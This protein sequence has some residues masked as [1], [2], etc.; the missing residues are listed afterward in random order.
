MSSTAGVLAAAL[1]CT[2]LPAAAASLELTTIEPIPGANDVYSFAGAD[3]D[4]VNINGGADQQNYV[5]F[6]RP[7]QGQ[8]FTTPSGT[9]SFLI[10][11]IWIR[12]AGYTNVAPGNGTFWNLANGA[13]YTIRV[14][15]PSKNGQAGFALSAE[16]Y[17]ATGTENGGV[18]W[19]GGGT[20][21]DDIWLHFTLAT[22]VSLAANTKYGFDLTATVAGGGNYFEWLGT[23]N[24][25]VLPG[26][27]AYT[28]TAAHVP[29][30]SVSTNVGDRVFLVQLGHTVP[31]VPPQLTAPLRFVPIGET[32]QV[33]ATIPSI[34]NAENP[35]IL[36]LTNNNPGLI[37]LPGGAS[38]VTLNFAAG[39]TN[40]QSFGVQV[41]ATGI[42]NISVV[43]NASFTEASIQIGTP[44]LALEPFDYD[45]AVQIYVDGANGGIGFGEPWS[46]PTFADTIV[47]GLT[48]GT[49]PGL[50]TSSNAASVVGTGEAFR[51]LP[52]ALG[53]VGGGTLY[54]GFLVQAP[55][56]LFDWGGLSLFNGPTAD[57][58]FMGTVLSVSANDTWGFSQG[59]NNQM[60]FAGSATPGAQVD[61]LV[62]RIDFPSTNGG[63]ALVSFYAN[64]PLNNDEPYSPTG[65][66]YVNNFMFDRIRLGTSDYLVFDEI[67][68]GTRWTNVM[69]F[70]GTPQPLPPP[71]PALSVPARFIPVGQNTPLTVVIP[72]SSPRPLSLTIS[73]DNPAAFSISSTNAALTTLTFGAGAT[74]V[75]TLNVH[76]LAA[77]AATLTVISNATVNTATL[78]IASQVSA[79]EPFAYEAIPEG[80]PGS[81]GGIGFDFN[82][83]TGGGSVVSPGLTFPGFVSSSNHASIAGATVGGSGNAIRSLLL[84]SGNYGGVGGGT[85]WV[86]FLIQGAFPETPQIA[87]VTLGTAFFMGLD[88]TTANN[89]KWGF[90]GPGAGPTGFPNSVAPSANT[91]LL[92]YRLDFPSV[93]GDLITVT[94]Y[95]NPPVGP[96]PP[97]VPTG[98]AAANLFTFN[99]IQLGTDFNMNFDEIRVGGSWA[100]VVPTELAPSLSIIRSSS[101]QVQISWPTGGAYTLMSS[102]NLLGPW[103]NSGLSITPAGGND[104]ATDVISGSAKFYRLE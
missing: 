94:M 77:G 93:A 87:G 85:V 17:A 51:S 52:G 50:I 98:S 73:N 60:N 19:T 76:T 12:H 66:G 89:G 26:G 84:S 32:V 88:T 37:S 8:T 30:D 63:Q 13:V 83:W 33:N 62:Y 90:T 40:V 56:G 78:A 71:T 31:A 36:V 103:S 23:T 86:S 95:A 7:T 53:G 61:F 99:Q 16:T 29:G 35:A 102:T 25:N 58:L 92:V 82:A 1:L 43:T 38:T 69:K 57:S 4:A 24:D 10:S 15:D 80:L 22:P 100:E 47:E 70:V 41:L 34:A 46:Q 6:D 5:A 14:T 81:A 64:P 42:G 48:Y 55:S 54:V 9:G 72:A 3:N 45:P 44:V 75:Q 39:A 97:A 79:S 2:S 28:G 21:G 65:S 104:V 68:I 27:E 11:D 49:D 18:Q 20:V 74:N 91:D 67:R 59:G 101:T 96:T